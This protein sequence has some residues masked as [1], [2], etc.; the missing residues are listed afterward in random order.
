MHSILNREISY[1]IV[2][3]SEKI[4]RYVRYQ[5]NATPTFYVSAIFLEVNEERTTKLTSSG[6]VIR[7]FRSGLYVTQ[8]VV[9]KQR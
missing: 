3:V 8:A 4:I 7:Y 6:K 9:L 5:L 1:K 2:P